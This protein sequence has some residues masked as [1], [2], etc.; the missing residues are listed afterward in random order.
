MPGTTCTS[1]QPSSPKLSR[2]CLV[3]CTS[4]G[5]VMY[6]HLVM[7]ATLVRST[8]T[9]GRRGSRR[10]ADPRLG[11]ARRRAPLRRPHDDGLVDVHLPA[12]PSHRRSPLVVYVHGGFWR[13]G[14]GPDA[15]PPAGE[16]AGGGG[17]RRRAAGVPPGRRG[18]RLAGHLRRR[19]RRADAPARAARRDRRPAPRRRHAGRALRRRAPRA[20]AGQPAGTAVDAG[21]RPRAGR[22]PARRRRSRAWASGAAVDLLGGTPEQVPE[23]YDAADPATRMRTRPACQVVVVHGDRTTTCRCRA[24]AAWP[25]RFDWL[26]YRELPGV[27]HFA[28]IDPLSRAWPAVLSTLRGEQVSAE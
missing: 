8:V 17:A 6:S 9:R 11:A 19:R 3:A 22:R 2:I 23:A 25:R 1:S 14:L 26:D 4:T 20:L 18:R 27:D 28:V 15:R 10:R 7:P 16:R 5:A 12:G 24:A 21:R 13:A